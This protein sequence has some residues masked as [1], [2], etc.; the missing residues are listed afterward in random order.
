MNIRYAFNWSIWIAFFTALYVFFYEI[1]PLSKYG[2]MPCTFVALPIYFAV[3]AKA[4]EYF[5]HCSSAVAGV[6]WA[7]VSIWMTSCVESF[8]LSENATT[9]LVIFVISVLLCGGHLLLEGR[10]I[11]SRIPMIFGSVA[12]ILMLG[13]EKWPYILATLCL[14]ISLGLICQ[15]GRRFLD[16]TG[17]WSFSRSSRM[18]NPAKASFGIQNK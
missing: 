8:G 7:A 3:G 9:T 2:V 5:D 13:L 6:A 11:F 17:K 4:S 15:L 16:V 10:G 12:S 1:S 14:G 18:K